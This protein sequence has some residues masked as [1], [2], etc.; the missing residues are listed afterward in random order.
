M[1]FKR[2]KTERR[3]RIE[4]FGAVNLQDI[5]PKGAARAA[6]AQRAAATTKARSSKAKGSDSGAAGAQLDLFAENQSLRAENARLRDDLTRERDRASRDA[7]A[8]EVDD[9]IMSGRMLPVQRAWALALGEKD[10][11]ALKKYIAEAKVIPMLAI[12]GGSA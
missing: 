5:S 12:C 6:A 3:A 11:P 10:R 9:A 7:L 8:R 2:A 4:V 1:S